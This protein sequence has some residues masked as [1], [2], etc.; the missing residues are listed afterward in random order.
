MINKFA[1]LLIAAFLSFISVS[2]A[3]TITKSIGTSSRDY[4]TVTAWEADHADNVIYNDLDIALGEMYADSDF[5]E[6]VLINS[7]FLDFGGGN[8]TITL[9]VVAADRH[10]GT[11]QSSN[12]RFVMSTAKDIEVNAA[13]TLDTTLQ[14]IDVDFGS[15]N[16]TRGID[17]EEQTGN[18]FVKNILAHNQTRTAGL[19]FVQVR[20]DATILNSIFYDLLDSSGTA[21]A[22]GII[23]TSQAAAEV[24]KI[25]NV[26]IHDITND[27]TSGDARGLTADDDATTTVQNVVITQVD[28]TATGT[29]TCF[30]TSAPANATYDHNAASD[31]TAS[32]TG[33]LDSITT[34]NQYVSTT[35]GSEDLH[36]Q[37]TA[38]DIFEAGADFGT[39][40][41]VNFDIDN[42]DRDA[43]A[44]TWSMGAHDG[45]NLRAGGIK[46]GLVIMVT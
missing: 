18:H 20:E 11:S 40:D 38:A 31:T 26:T 10:D 14:W 46:K 16:I 5:D 21:D 29:D 3:A 36:I 12:A 32:G 43:G 1:G 37:D 45:N 39:T 41:G 8:I 9:S 6:N 30:L 35:V 27:G 28:G 23:G 13:S 15:Q 42:Y 2:W 22:T 44:T 34:A 7:G 4:S 17:L 19:T 33:S 25:Q 24:L